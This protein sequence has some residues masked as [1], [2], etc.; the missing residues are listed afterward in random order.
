MLDR[1]Y[2]RE[3]RREDGRQCGYYASEQNCGVRL[4]KFAGVCEY[5][6]VFT[7][8]LS[9]AEPLSALTHAARAWIWVVRHNFEHEVHVSRLRMQ[10]YKLIHHSCEFF[11]NLRRLIEYVCSMNCKR[12]DINFE[13]D[14]SDQFT[15]C[16][17]TSRARKKL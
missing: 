8:L 6:Y 4:R 2:V 15:Q 3:R 14:N 9:V 13:L 7:A 16:A 11:D 5:M 17:H 12:S 10:Q 1:K